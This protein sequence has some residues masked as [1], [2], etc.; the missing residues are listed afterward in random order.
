M[1][2]P[3]LTILLCAAAAPAPSAQSEGSERPAVRRGPLDRGSSFAPL[4]LSGTIAGGEHL[5]EVH[6]GIGHFFFNHLSVEFDLVAGRVD[7]GRRRRAVARTWDAG[8]D[9]MGRWHF[10]RFE[11]G[12]IYLDAGTGI[13]VFGSEFPIG[14]TRFNFTL[15]AG[16]GVRVRLWEPLALIGGA[17]WFHVSNA[18]LWGRARNP[19]HNALQLYAGLQFSW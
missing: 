8:G 19:A 12:S 14:G 10:L 16:A 1:H 13:R 18:S 6:A 4:Y 15:Q 2:L 7:Y 5:V 17:R 11:P 3:A 9:L